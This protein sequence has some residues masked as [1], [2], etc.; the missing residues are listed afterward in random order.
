MSTPVYDNTHLHFQLPA[1]GT[2]AELRLARAPAF[3]TC[4]GEPDEQ[5]RLT[6]IYRGLR[7]EY[8]P[9]TGWGRVRGSLHTFAHGHN[10]G[11]FGWM[12]AALACDEL[13]VAL[14]MPPDWLTVRRLEVGLNIPVPTPPREFLQSL[15]SHKKSL[16][17]A[18]KPPAG[19][20][21]PLEYSAFHEAY[22]LKFYD[23][24][25][26]ARLQGQPHPPGHLLRFEVVY[27]RARPLQQLTGYAPL[28]LAD[29]PRPLVL[30]AFQEQLR[31]QWYRT[32]RLTPMDYTGL[33]LADSALIHAANDPAFWE[34]MRKSQP[35]ATYTRNHARARRLL[36]QLRQRA[37]AHP[38][39][40]AFERGLEGL[41]VF[42]YD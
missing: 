12:E 25:T 32:Q 1:A 13:A 8:V 5:G 38:F 14:A 26:Y 4:S 3:A 22:R 41:D 42:K 30:A 29:L 16:F 17:T 40:V 28:T 11:P 27:S 15:V 37:E 24:G 20:A 31:L 39:D 7:L 18:L 34:A 6:A 33:S 23:K 9:A 2:G 10:T 36:E 35:R 19:A 21:R